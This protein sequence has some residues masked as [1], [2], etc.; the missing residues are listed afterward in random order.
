MRD[1]SLI[2][3]SILLTGQNSIQLPVSPVES[4]FEDGQG[5]WMKKVMIVS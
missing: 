3:S 2:L 4:I 1:D 5:V